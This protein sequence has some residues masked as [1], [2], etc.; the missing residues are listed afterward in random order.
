MYPW[1]LFVFLGFGVAARSFLLCWSMQHVERTDPERFIFGPYFLVPFLLCVA[2]LL[3]EIG[4]VA[5]SQGTLRLALALPAALVGLAMV[6]DRPDELYQG[7]LSLFNARL[8][9]TPL[10]LTLLAAAG[11]YAYA[12]L[13]RVPRGRSGR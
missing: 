2:V 13:R 11:F 3:L 4:L 7:F 1:A 5:R 12:A 6:G 9:G 8:G 10:S